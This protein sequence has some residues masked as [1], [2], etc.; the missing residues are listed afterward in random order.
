MLGLKDLQGTNKSFLRKFINYIRKEFYNI[1]SWAQ[2][3]ETFLSVTSEFLQLARVFV[4]DKP[5]QPSLMFGGK[6]GV[7]HIEEPFSCSSLGPYPG[8]IHIK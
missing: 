7:F 5:F 4:P 6:A 2:S 1:G 3:N 8:L